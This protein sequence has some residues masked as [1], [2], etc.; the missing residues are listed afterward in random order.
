MQ[1]VFNTVNTI[2]SNPLNYANAFNGYLIQKS[3][4]NTINTTNTVYNGVSQ[5]YALRINGYICPGTTDTYTFQLYADDGGVLYINDAMI[6]NCTY[7]GMGTTGAIVLTGGIWY[8]IVI[9]HTQGT[10]GEQL[11]MNYKK[12]T[13]TTFTTLTHST[14]TSGI[15]FTYDQDKTIM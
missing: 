11:T 15:Q 2:F 13:Q 1:R 5:Y 6:T 9:E 14:G 3:I 8:P 10:G 7:T 12:T 4:I